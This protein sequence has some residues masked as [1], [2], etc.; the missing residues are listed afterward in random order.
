M[1]IIDFKGS[2]YEGVNSSVLLDSDYDKSA[3]P[4]ALKFEVGDIPVSMSRE[5]IEYTDDSI[6]KIQQKSQIPSKSLQS[7]TTIKTIK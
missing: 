3:L 4:V 7:F 1:S 6:S 2:D 5:T